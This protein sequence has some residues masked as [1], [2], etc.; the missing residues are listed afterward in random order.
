MNFSD[1]LKEAKKLAIKKPIL[2]LIKKAVVMA[3]P[4]APIPM[5]KAL[6]IAITKNN[7]SYREQIIEQRKGP[8]EDKK[9]SKKYVKDVLAARRAK[10]EVSTKQ[11]TRKIYKILVPDITGM[12]PVKLDVNTTIFIRP[13]KDIEVVIEKWVNRESAKYPKF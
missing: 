3:I 7:K 9:I 2:P 13:G 5:V 11:N 12:T 4:I 8:V 1:R 10:K 6:P